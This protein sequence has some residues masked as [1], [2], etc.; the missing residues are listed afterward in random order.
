[1]IKITYVAVVVGFVA[2]L[3]SLA[4]GILC[5][6]V[7]ATSQETTDVPTG[8]AML[9]S[10]LFFV[11]FCGAVNYLRLIAGSVAKEPVAEAE[12]S[13]RPSFRG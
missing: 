8:L 11:L 10:G 1:M 4:L 6:L 9:G 13:E 5:L 12:I 7:E 2:G 3:I